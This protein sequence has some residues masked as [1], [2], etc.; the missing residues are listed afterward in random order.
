MARAGRRRITHTPPAD[1]PFTG[2]FSGENR[3]R[4]PVPWVAM[5]RAE[6]ENQK[7][8]W[9]DLEAVE[10]RVS[11]IPSET[12]EVQGQEQI[13]SPGLLGCFEYLSA[14]LWFTTGFI[15][16]GGSEESLQKEHQTM[17]CLWSF[18]NFQSWCIFAHLYM[19]SLEPR[20]DGRIRHLAMS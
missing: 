18:W 1:L 19:E 20:G 5:G 13:S 9:W 6:S 10:A 4:D 2:A 8:G 3:Q 16:P 12:T 14:Y 11:K 17:I 15:E 7:L